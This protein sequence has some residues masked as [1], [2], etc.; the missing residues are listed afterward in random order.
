MQDDLR[1]VLHEHSVFTMSVEC[2]VGVQDLTPK[3]QNVRQH[4]E[5][6]LNDYRS[7]D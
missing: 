5:A 7:T 6:A 1:S 3:L 2:C 4:L